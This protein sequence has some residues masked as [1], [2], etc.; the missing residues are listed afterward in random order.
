MR[1][2]DAVRQTKEVKID[3][4]TP[5]GNKV[6]W[7]DATHHIGPALRI[8]PRFTVDAEDDQTGLGNTLDVEYDPVEGRFV[9]R[10]ASV[11]S[12]TGTEITG[13]ELRQVR[14]AEALQQ[15]SPHCVA[16]TL[17]DDSNTAVTAADVA[18]EDQRLLP[19]WLAAT[20]AELPEGRNLPEPAR[21]EAREARLDAVQLVYGVAALT[22]QPPAKAIERELG[23]APRTAA[24]WIHLARQAGRLEGLGYSAG[25]PPRG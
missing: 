3:V 25:R 9:I 1:K 2:R 20:L 17:D 8:V 23:V 5:E 18:A 10:Q 4:R 14:L 16:F 13:T 15:A 19:Q 7:Q 24:H 11:R 22:G 21:T 12:L 6:G